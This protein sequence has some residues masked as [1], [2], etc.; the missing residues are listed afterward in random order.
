MP[1]TRLFITAGK[2]R[3]ERAAALLEAELEE[4][5]LPVAA[6]EIDEAAELWSVSVYVDEAEAAQIEARIVALLEENGLPSGIGHETLEETDWVS[7]TLAGL[8]PVRAGRFLVHGSHD[9]AAARPFDTAIEIDAGQ[10]FG[11]G[12]HGT[13]AGCLEMIGAQLKRRRFRNALDTGTGSGVLAIGLAKAAHVPVLATDIDPVATEVARHNVAL[14]GASA[15]V[16]CATATGMKDREIARRAPY[17]L[18]VANIL[19]GPLQ[20]LARDLA[21]H[22]APGGTVILSGLLPHQRARITATY[23]AHGLRLA[24][25]HIRDG[26]LTLV[27]EK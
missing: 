23:R 2:D 15:L 17:D 19:A 11:T 27:L 24:R 18:I 13:T 9:R 5:G 3:A 12:H 10:A 1:Q 20:G 8:K 21:R 26:W 4:D 22:L 6:F 16:A 25:A 7:A 14:N